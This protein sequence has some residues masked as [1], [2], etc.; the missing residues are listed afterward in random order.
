IESGVDY[1]AVALLEEAMTLRENGINVPIL[2]LGRVSAQYAQIAAENNIALTI[3][4]EDW[5]KELPD[6]EL[7]AILN[8]HLKIDSGMGRSGVRSVG[9]IEC[10]VTQLKQRKDIRLEGVY[11]HF[12]T[13]D[14]VK[15]PYFDLQIERFEQLLAELNKLI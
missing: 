8:V 1:L 2:V 3:Y 4:Q 11:T 13:A 7:E 15:S 6:E 5:F 12:A 10:V 14:E 9:E